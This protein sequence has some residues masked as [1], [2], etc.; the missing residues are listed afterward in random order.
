M[1]N[2][3]RERAVM[4]VDAPAARRA[5]AL[6]PLTR[7]PAFR[8]YWVSS[9]LFFSGFWAQ[10]VVLAW[11]AFDLTQSEFAVA[12]FGA[13]RFFPM[14][15]GP[16]GGALS[17]RVDRVR[18]LVAASVVALASTVVMAVLV[19]VGV[20]AYWQVVLIG[21]LLGMMQAPLQPARF[22]LVMDLV[23]REDV[24]SANALNMAT[25]MGARVLAP[26]ISGVLIARF[27]AGAALWAAVPWYVSGTLLL[28]RV[29][30]RP[31]RH[32]RV[33]SG[34]IADLIEGFAITVRHREMAGVL[35]VSVA[36]NA[37]AWPVIQAF[38]PV[39][40]DRVLESGAVGL[41]LMVA[42]TGVGSLVGAIGIAFLG[43]FR[44]KGR[45]FL[46]GTL[47]FGLS[48]SAFALAGNM[49]L[50]LLL[51]LLGGIA[52]AGFGVMQSTIM[53]LMAPDELRGRAM[54][55]LMLA[56]GIMPF[57]TLVQGAIASSVGVVETT[58]VAGLMLVA[59]TG[60]VAAAI[61]G[62]RRA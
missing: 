53:M 61:P 43:D 1:S 30:E 52:S 29:R 58:F 54:G 13:V 62:L 16:L 40:A 49:P 24:S 37:F 45:L 3:S 41:G 44:G 50:A 15:L 31:D 59:A 25:L 8:D 36:A 27:G 2:G 22:T 26:A 17:E 28:L 11:L 38:L 48:L 34:V 14:L 46:G 4:S 55:V 9:L 20:G 23:R 60:V 51:L 56:I 5:A 35:I 57:A 10:T 12:V 7:Y 19:G 21:L 47:A 32:A 39:F 42:A 18:L 6:A 33:A